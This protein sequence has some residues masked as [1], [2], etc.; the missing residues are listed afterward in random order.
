MNADRSRKV[1]SS[2]LIDFSVSTLVR[3]AYRWNAC[4]DRVADSLNSHSHQDTKIIVNA[5]AVFMC[6]GGQRA[7][8]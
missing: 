4:A 3:Q 5:E 1:F 2:I 8:G 6:N 7:Y